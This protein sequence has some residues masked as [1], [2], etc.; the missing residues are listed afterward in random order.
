[1]TSTKKSVFWQSGSYYHPRLFGM[2]E[3]TL[4]QPREHARVPRNHLPQLI[5]PG[6]WSAEKGAD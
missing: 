3:G 1:M 6:P 2:V 4:S 5:H